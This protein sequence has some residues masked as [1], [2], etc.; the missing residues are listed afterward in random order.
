[1]LDLAV[2][3]VNYNTRDHLHKC[4]SSVCASEGDFKFDVCVVDNASC[5]NSCDMVRTSFPQVRLIPSRVNRGFACANNIALRE[6]GFRNPNEPTG[7]PV[8]KLPRYALLLNPDTVVPPEAFQRML[9]FMDTHPEVGA[10]G[11]K[12]VLEDG[13][14]DL[15][16]RRSFPTPE[17]SLYRMTGLSRLFPRHHVFGRYNLTFCDPDT[18]MEVD[19][20]VGAFMLVRREAIRQVGLLDE[21]YFMYGEDLDWAYRLRQ[22]GW[23]TYYYPAVTVLHVKRAASRHSPRAQQEFYRAMHIFYNKHFAA[24]T[25]WLLH[26]LTVAGITLQSRLV[27]IRQ[28]LPGTHRLA[29]HGGRE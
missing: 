29:E 16:C 11:P 19:S 28:S 25:P 9:Q 4:L 13:S 1:M 2:V 27:R 21:T 6:Y 23:K 7:V 12:L 17:V 14:L 20:V 3:V 5:D 8:S 26:R 22:R 10:S 18:E 15:A 24:Q